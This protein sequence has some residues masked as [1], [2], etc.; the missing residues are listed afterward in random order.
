MASE[1]A[2]GG[3]TDEQPADAQKKKPGSLKEKLMKCPDA[4][5]KVL[6]NCYK[7]KKN[8][9]TSPGSNYKMPHSSMGKPP[10]TRPSPSHDELPNRQP[11]IPSEER[12][13]RCVEMSMH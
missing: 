2:E 7:T 6:T 1:R 10:E 11:E 4:C 3:P 8:E 5:W 12:E 9:S 13:A